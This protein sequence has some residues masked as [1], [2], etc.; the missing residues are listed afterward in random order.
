[1]STLRKRNQ[2]EGLD[3]ESPKRL[4]GGGGDAEELYN[5]EDMYDDMIDQDGPPP[6]EDDDIADGAR[7]GEEDVAFGDITDAH[8]SRWARPAVPSS[9]WKTHENDLNL[10]W[11]D[12]DM[13]GGSPLA[14]NPNGKKKALGAKNGTVPIIRLFGVNETGNS[15][16]VFIHGFTSYAYFALPR[17][18]EVSENNDN[19]GKIRAILETNLKAKLGGQ[20]SK[21]NSSNGEQSQACLGV[22]RVT[23][24][25][26]IMGY[27]PSHTNFLKVYVAMPG[28]VPKLKSIMEDG[29]LL[30]GIL[31]DNGQEVRESMIFQPFECNVPYVLRYMID[32]DITGASWLSLPKGTYRLRES[33]S[34]KGTHCQIEADIFFNEI[35]PRKP[36]GEWSKVA[37][38][39]ILSFDIEC[40]GRKGYFPEAEHDPVIQIANCVSVYGESKPT[41]QNVFTLKGCLPIVGAQVI[42]SNT[43]K[44][45]LLK[46]R[47]F[48]H[49][50]DADIFTGYNVQNF[51][52][53]Y[54]LDRAEALWKKNDPKLRIFTQWG[55][56]KNTQ[57]KKRETMF[58]SS[59]YGRR[60]NTETTIEGRVIFD[61]LPYMQRNHKLSSYTLN[62]VCS[63]FLS[64]QKEDVHHSII[65]D[66]QAGSDADRHRLAVYCLK[67]A[68]L[69]QRLMD[70]LSVL[71]NYVEMARVTGVPVS[72]LISRGQQIKVFSMILR[73]C[74]DVDLLVPTLKKSG[75]N[76]DEG[77]EGAT[78][79]DPIKSYYEIPIATLDFASLYPSIM[80]AYNLCYSTMVSPQ[81][82]TKIDPSKFKRSENGHNFVHSNVKK[83]ILPIIL[84]E[85]LSARKQAKKDMKNAPNEFEKAVQNG[86]QLALKI[87]A[88]SVYG[89]TGAAVGQLP[90]VPIAASVTSYGRFLLEK[91]KA[92]V[93]EH[94]TQ[95]HGYEHN[96]QV[97]YGDTDS[98]MVKFGTKTVKE[99]FPLAIEAAKKCSDIFPDPI[100]LEFEKV[101]YPYLLMNKKR[102]AGL[103]WTEPDKYDY[104]D[105]K[106]LE[107]V[108][109]DNCAL[110]REV[111]Q[112]SLNKIIIE[113]DVPSAI[114]YVKSQIADL[115][116]NKMDISRLVITKS[117]NKGAEYALGL[118][119]KKEDYKMKQAHVELAARMRK[120][121]PGSAPQMGDRVPYVIIT[122]AKGAAN[123]EKAEDPIYV[124]EN[125][126][127][128]DSKWYLSNQL[129]KPLTR[130]FEPI[131]DNVEKSLLKGDHTR[132]IFIPTPTAKKGSLM[133]F[134]HKKATCMGCKVSISAN[135]GNLCKY[136]LPKEA[137]IY[138]EKLAA[139]KEAELRYAHLWSEA[140]RIHGT[141]HTDIMCTGDGCACQFYRRKKVQTDIRLAQVQVDKFGR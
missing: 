6:P 19:L 71:I 103:M 60:N 135:E 115:L 87:S 120:R 92:Y 33:E 109:R 24:K 93:E 9:A 114:N 65:S 62:S 38:L 36:E 141:L 126:I 48:L 90:C 47:T 134:A 42:S 89:F 72:F 12:I 16:A 21:G 37:P 11:L 70:K 74:R 57:T 35:I 50:S 23:D 124:L 29:I 27:D 100:L 118:G 31:N 119:G 122:A 112:T 32:K 97:V 107:T 96:A 113:R 76:S 13:I 95:A 18:Y 45:M 4:R 30:P 58:Q 22:Q 105:T 34:E 117:L 106:G 28:M 14:K 111:I 127:P 101:Y 1:M 110:V 91:T 75:P 5:E 138:L 121:D 108:R 55:R 3:E 130:I 125:N 139:L 88:N 56:V 77:Y 85:L 26:S 136:C 99:T 10:Q 102:Y 123:F 98:V 128:I 80:Q 86:R 140:Q 116:Q 81:E 64:Q 78:V 94:Y 83:G 129:S 2:D 51:D 43:E 20:F 15:V 73:K 41:V 53:P 66:L 132:K 137:Q 46:W 39:R 79:L 82:A 67:D 49:A 63:E 59:A 69:P 61:M 40:Q 44:D 52:I 84:G 54:L 131:I 7:A 8:R 25:Q 104:M 68:L 17:G 133:M